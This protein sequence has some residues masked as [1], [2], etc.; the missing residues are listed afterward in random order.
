MRHAQRW[1]WLEIAVLIM[2][3]AAILRLGG[4]LA[5]QWRQAAERI[6]LVEADLHA[7]SIADY[8]ADP[9]N[10]FIPLISP[11]ILVDLFGHLSPDWKNPFD[12]PSGAMDGLVETDNPTPDSTIT[13]VATQ[14]PTIRIPDNTGEPTE[15]TSP[16]ATPPGGNKPTPTP[17]LIRGGLASATPTRAGVISPTP[18]RTPTSGINPIATPTRTPTRRIDP[19]VTSTQIIEPA[20][21]T[22]TQLPEQTQEPPTQEPPT[23]VP[24]THEPPT[25]APPTQEPPTQAPPTQAPPT[26]RTPTPFATRDPTRA[27]TPTAH[28]TPGGTAAPT[29]PEPPVI[30]SV[31]DS[32]CSTTGNSLQSE[33]ECLIGTYGGESFWQI[34]LDLLTLNSGV[35]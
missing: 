1:S 25:Q 30:P 14:T 34:L 2:L 31:K 9:L 3:A 28:Y 10:A 19:T 6:G 7:K 29:T 17:T 35:D 11:G 4:D 8:S 5:R 16:T 33:E 20:T 21:R 22:P 23:Q 27:V 18:S 12:L 24:P 26:Q 32:P 15:P 13:I